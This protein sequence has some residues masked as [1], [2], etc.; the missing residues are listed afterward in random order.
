MKVCIVTQ[1]QR[2]SQSYQRKMA[3][4]APT[5]SGREG[6]RQGDEGGE[7][8]RERQ[9]EIVKSI[10]EKLPTSLLPL[11]EERGGKRERQRDRRRERKERERGQRPKESEKQSQ[12]HQRHIANVTATTGKDGI[13]SDRS[14]SIMF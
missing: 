2:Q 7:W 9:R 14:P 6:K 8:E 11:V 3:D 13:G 5:A 1:R 10:K 12:Y 4:V